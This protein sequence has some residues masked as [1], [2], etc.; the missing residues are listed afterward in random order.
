MGT[1]TV[2]EDNIATQFK[3]SNAIQVECT[4]IGSHSRSNAEETEVSTGF[5]AKNK[6]QNEAP[7]EDCEDPDGEYLEI[8]EQGMDTLYLSIGDCKH[9]NEEIGKTTGISTNNEHE[10]ERQ[11][12][13]ESLF[14]SPVP[15]PTFGGENQES[16]RRTSKK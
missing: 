4:T 12:P 7:G 13:D 14:E 16:P 1:E 10:A 6:N 2:I 5:V 3:I 11:E 8:S 9:K 15:F